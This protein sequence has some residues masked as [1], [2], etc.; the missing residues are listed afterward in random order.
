MF[1]YLLTGI[2]YE[3][4]SK[5]FRLLETLEYR[6]ID[7]LPRLLAENPA[8]RP[9]NLSKLVE[10][11][12]SAPAAELEKAVAPKAPPRRKRRVF[13]AL[14]GVAALVAAIAGYFLFSHRPASS[15]TDDF[16]AAFSVG[17]I[18]EGTRQ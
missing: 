5:V 6:W 9:T 18:Y 4:G 12:K 13:L 15:A 14:A 10:T 2:W 7:V 16:D 11:L 1:V 8:E 17:G 3:P